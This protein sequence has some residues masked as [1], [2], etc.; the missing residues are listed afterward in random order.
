MAAP[1]YRGTDGEIALSAP[2]SD[3]RMVGRQQH[4]EGRG[5]GC[6]GERFDGERGLPAELEGV[7][8][9]RVVDLRGPRTVGRQVEHGDADEAGA[10]GLKVDAAT[11]AV[12]AVA[13]P[14]RDVAV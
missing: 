14:G 6:A 12:H 2:L 13:L 1:G 3:Q 10:P 4:D 7:P 11:G 5:P 9:A 8:G